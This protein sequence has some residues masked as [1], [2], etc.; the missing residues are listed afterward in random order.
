MEI[1]T[2]DKPSP[3]LFTGLGPNSNSNSNN[4]NINNNIENE[5]KKM[6]NNF[7]GVGGNS[8]QQQ[9]SFND[10]N[11]AQ[12][13]DNL[14][15]RDWKVEN[16]ECKQEIDPMC[17]EN[18]LEN[19]NESDQMDIGYGP[20]ANN[21]NDAYQYGYNTNNNAQPFYEGSSSLLNNNSISNSN[22][23]YRNGNSIN[24][25]DHNSPYNSY[26]V[27]PSAKSQ[28]PTWYH[29]PPPPATAVNIHPSYYPPQ[30]F[31][32][33]YPAVNYMASATTSSDHNMRNMIQMTNR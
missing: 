12:Y 16:V 2:M 18:V 33:P 3:H 9:G 26:Q 13:L 29:P 14:T 19:H 25:N 1:C 11:N 4:N 8:C 30:N 6:M 10:G 23:M 17:N 32:Q 15:D 7:E 21:Y 27:I 20:N 31:Y 24:S 28:L 22:F 5:N